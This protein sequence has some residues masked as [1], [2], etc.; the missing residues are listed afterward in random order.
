ML[1]IERYRR[2]GVGRLQRV[3]LWDA[4]LRELHGRRTAGAL[5]ATGSGALASGLLSALAAKILA[6]HGGPAALA[7]LATLQ[8][9]R[10]GA[11]VAATV[12]GQTAV[13]QG[14]SARSG[15]PRRE[16]VRTAAL[17]FLA[18][19][20]LVGA[21]CFLFPAALRRVPGLAPLSD[22][23][24]RWLAAGVLFSSI[25][26]FLTSILNALGK[27]GTL[28]A[29]QIVAP[30]TLAVGMWVLAAGMRPRAGGMWPIMNALAQGRLIPEH[31]IPEHPILVVDPL[32]MLL[33]LTA[34]IAA[35]AAAWP[36]AASWPDWK[37]WVLAPGKVGRRKIGHGEVD[38][39]NAG[40]GKLECENLWSSP[41]ARAFLSISVAMLVS[42]LI[43]SGT[44]IG[45]RGRIIAHQGLAAAGWF[46]AA[47][48]ISMNHAS[49]LLASLQTYCLPAL[50]RAKSA[51]EQSEH[52]TGVLTLALAAAAVMIAG[53]ALIKPWVLELFYAPSFRGASVLL[54]WT[55][56]GDYLKI[57]SWILSLPLLA[58]ADMK[59]F[60]LLDAAAYATFGGASVALSRWLP[61]AE[62]A[63]AAFACMYAVHLAAGAAL[64]Y[65]RCGIHLGRSA[66]AVWAGGLMLVA[67]VSGFT[68]NRGA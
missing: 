18:G 52:L 43:A 1:A 9:A 8:Q 7:A 22:A 19:T 56:L 57:G 38:G 28:A 6:A 14:A 53:I 46:D 20:L 63:A 32:A 42:G 59:A 39:G 66:V 34:A 55:L 11:L 62:S 12:N 54:R 26:V 65:W 35:A 51:R 50:A 21:G 48:N 31:P 16:Y 3:Y 33:A 15:E 40:R 36:L 64:A 68:W 41:A 4:P 58:R 29:L 24:F 23:A 60:L 44:V 67:V 30:L 25:F 47:W 37:D 10:Q 61:G 49:L 45:V 2:A 13:I 27:I 17:L 5:T